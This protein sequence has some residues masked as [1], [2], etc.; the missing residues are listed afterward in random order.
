M[1]FYPSL[2]WL[3]FFILLAAHIQLLSEHMQTATR[4]HA[5]IALTGTFMMFVGSKLGR[6]FL[7]IK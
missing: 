3:G 6:E 4:R 7:G 1:D 5:L 2:F